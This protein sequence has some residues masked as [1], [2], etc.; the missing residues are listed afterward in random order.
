[1]AEQKKT[2][3][4][5]AEA[6]KL[7]SLSGGRGEYWQH[8]ADIGRRL[9]PNNPRFTAVAAKEV[10]DINDFMDSVTARTATKTAASTPAE[11]L[12]FGA[13][14]SLDPRAFSPM[15]S[16]SVAEA[17]ARAASEKMNQETSPPS[18][19][20]G[21]SS[22]QQTGEDF[23]FDFDTPSQ[24]GQQEDLGVN[25]D[26]EELSR[27]R[28]FGK[29]EEQ[30]DLGGTTLPGATTTRPSVTTQTPPVTT[31]PTFTQGQVSNLQSMNID[32]T[33]L[34]LDES[35]LDDQS[36]IDDRGVPLGY[37]GQWQ[38]VATKLDLARAYQAT[39]DIEA[40][41]DILQEVLKEGDEQQK[42]EAHAIL[43]KL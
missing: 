33:S 42:S 24:Q 3:E 35:I 40:C 26:L 13:A 17:I 12:G 21:S 23:S 41:R 10:P 36:I 8:A 27:F 38:D 9:M 22:G 11:P 25:L 5:E 1:M 37:D 31:A 30:V 39:G 15:E 29:A 7:Y 18:S 34:S 16:A 14:A 20:S 28:N 6:D 32:D 19:V 43:E 4:F 2:Q